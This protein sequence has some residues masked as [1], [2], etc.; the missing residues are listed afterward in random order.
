MGHLSTNT[1]LGHNPW[2]F[3]F[4]L[5][6]TRYSLLVTVEGF[7]WATAATFMKCSGLPLS[8]DEQGVCPFLISF[9]LWEV[10]VA[11]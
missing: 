9:T 3:V 7:L 2:N 4:T 11:I 10:I 1:F 5:N 6:P 8:P